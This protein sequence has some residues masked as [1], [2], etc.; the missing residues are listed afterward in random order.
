MEELIRSRPDPGPFK[1]ILAT[2]FD[3]KI[4]ESINDFKSGKPLAG[5]GFILDERASLQICVSSDESLTLDELNRVGFSSVE[6]TGHGGLVGTIAMRDI[7]KL[8]IHSIRFIVPDVIS[9]K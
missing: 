7:E 3:R 1:P 4:V 8:G 6:V 2:T 5:Y 9:I